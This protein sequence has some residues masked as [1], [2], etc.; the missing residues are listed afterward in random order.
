MKHLLLSIHASPWFLFIFCILVLCQD[1]GGR[2]V[3]VLISRCCSPPALCSYCYIQSHF[4]ATFSFQAAGKL[5]FFGKMWIFFLSKHTCDKIAQQ[6]DK[7]L[8]TL[9]A[10]GADVFVHICWSWGYAGL[11][12][13][14]QG[15]IFVKFPPPHTLIASPCVLRRNLL[16]FPGAGWLW[17]ILFMLQEAQLHRGCECCALGDPSRV[18]SS[19]PPSCP[20]A[21]AGGGFRLCNSIPLLKMIWSCCRSQHLY[22]PRYAEV[23]FLP[24]GPEPHQVVLS[25]LP[26]CPSSF[27]HSLVSLPLVSLP[28]LSPCPWHPPRC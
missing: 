13:R 21:A 17:V 8:E 2:D 14:T 15:D 19:L 24:L 26:A 7:K 12:S 18:N 20:A 3:L 27:P 6:T 16:A 10:S 22:F 11:D 23:I 5:E 1:A 28:G 9:S 4:P 25:H